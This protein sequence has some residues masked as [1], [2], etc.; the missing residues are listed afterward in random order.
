MISSIGYMKLA[1][2]YENNKA[3]IDPVLRG[4]VWDVVLIG[5]TMFWSIIMLT[6]CNI[7]IIN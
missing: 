2:L 4:R 3:E 1:M 5:L 6:T 7:W